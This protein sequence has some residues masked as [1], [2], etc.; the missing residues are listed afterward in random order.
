MRE[1]KTEVALAATHR[2]SQPHVAQRT[3]K[4]LET[5]AFLVPMRARRAKEPLG[6][7]SQDQVG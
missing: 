5:M 4:P 1:M 3:I 7:K 6:S 2:L